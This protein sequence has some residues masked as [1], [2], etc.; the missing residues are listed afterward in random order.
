MGNRRRR[1]PLRPAALEREQ[2]ALAV[3]GKPALRG[4][5]RQTGVARR[6]DKRHGIRDVRA[7]HLPAAPGIGADALV[8]LAT[9]SVARASTRPPTA[10]G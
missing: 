1:R 6:R 8:K 4:A 7:D 2:P 9:S 10:S 3:A 5:K